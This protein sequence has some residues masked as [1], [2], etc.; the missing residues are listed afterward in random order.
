MCCDFSMRDSPLTTTPPANTPAEPLRLKDGRSG[1][2]MLALSS[3]DAFGC[4]GCFIEREPSCAKDKEPEGRRIDADADSMASSAI[5]ARHFNFFRWDTVVS[6]QVAALL[7]CSP[8]DD[9]ASLYVSQ[10]QTL[11]VEMFGNA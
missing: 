6:L 8:G 4:F 3:A 10:G 2:F 1:C 5:S 9:I 11:E 7:G